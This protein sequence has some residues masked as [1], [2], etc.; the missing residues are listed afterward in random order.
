M[1]CFILCYRFHA[2][3]LKMPN[4]KSIQ[5]SSN[6]L[7]NFRRNMNSSRNIFKDEKFIFKTSKIYRHPILDHMES[8]TTLI[9]QPKK[10]KVLFFLILKVYKK[11]NN[12]LKRI[13]LNQLSAT[14]EISKVE[15]WQKIFHFPMIGEASQILLK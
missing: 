14:K 1:W 13:K 10:S 2:V 3:N 15:F 8:T 6:L 9:G 11:L 4:F 7:E 5:L 12:L